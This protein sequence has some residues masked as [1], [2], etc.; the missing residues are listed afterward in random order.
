MFLFPIS[1][2]ICEQLLIETMGQKNPTT[3]TQSLLSP[4][5]FE[6]TT[7]SCELCGG[8]REIEKE[9]HSLEA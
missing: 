1:S 6:T 2:D 9:R 5:F 3:P 8:T 4:L 7:R